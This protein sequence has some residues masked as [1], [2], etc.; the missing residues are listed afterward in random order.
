M[1]RVVMLYPQTNDSRFDMDYFLNKH[2]PR[3]RE[4]F[5]DLGLRNI[6]VQ[7]GIASAAPGQ[8]APFM[9]ISSFLFDK[10]EDFQQGMAAQGAWIVGDVPNYTNVQPQIQIS[11]LVFAGT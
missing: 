2:I 7:Q 10:L 8:P 5:K 6:E 4:I 1:F 11:N 9:C 3:I